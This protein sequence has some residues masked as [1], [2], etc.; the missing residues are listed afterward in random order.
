MLADLF[1]AEDGQGRPQRCGPLPRLRSP[2]ELS[3]ATHGRCAQVLRTPE[4]CRGLETPWK[5]RSRSRVFLCSPPCRPRPAAAAAVRACACPA[6]HA[7]NFSLP[8]IRADSA[9]LARP[10]S[11]PPRWPVPRPLQSWRGTSTSIGYPG[12]AVSRRDSPHPRGPRGPPRPA[13]PPG[14]CPAPSSS[15]SPKRGEGTGDPVRTH[16]SPAGRC[17]RAH[18]QGPKR[19]P[20]L[21]PK[22]LGSAV[23]YVTW[24]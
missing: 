19:N 20:G 7:G 23:R 2:A 22:G 12:R 9:R 13:Q 17:S 3:D 10:S 6:L 18:P 14:Q 16:E 21:S 11:R 5:T 24:L 15:D 1:P 8:Y 4:R